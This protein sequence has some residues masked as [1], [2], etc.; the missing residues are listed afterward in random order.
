MTQIAKLTAPNG[1]KVLTAA[2]LKNFV[3][4][5]LGGSKNVQAVAKKNANTVAVLEYKKIGYI[6]AKGNLNLNYV[7]EQIKNDIQIANSEY[8]LK[9][10]EKIS[11]QGFSPKPVFNSANKTLEYGVLVN[12]G[13][14]QFANLYK[15]IL[16][17][18]GYLVLN[19]SCFP[20]DKINLADFK[21]QVDKSVNYNNFNPNRDKVSES[22]LENVILMNKFF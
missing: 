3:N 12:F 22:K 8:E 1:W 18:D 2:E 10:N 6:A 5:E 7:V 4:E 17:K 15:I 14:E 9:E 21:I 16:V 13:K 19:I 20:K 11:F